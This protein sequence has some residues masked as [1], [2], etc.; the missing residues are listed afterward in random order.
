[1]ST[2]L[3]NY[4]KAVQSGWCIVSS[5]SVFSALIDAVLFELTHEEKYNNASNERQ[6]EWRSEVASLAIAYVKETG[7]F[8][9]AFGIIAMEAHSKN[10][11]SYNGQF[12]TPENV[13]MFSGKAAFTDLSYSRVGVNRFDVLEPTCGTGAMVFGLLKSVEQMSPGQLA[14]INVVT[15]ELS[16]DYA[17]AFYAN[18]LLSE[19]CH[20]SSGV[21]FTILRG[22]TLEK[23]LNVMARINCSTEDHQI[24][25]PDKIDI[26]ML[27]FDLIIGNPPFGKININDDANW[28]R[29]SHKKPELDSKQFTPSVSLKKSV[30]GE[31]IFIDLATSLLK[32]DGV[33]AFVV[34][35]G[36]L[37]NSKSRNFRKYLL[38]HHAV[39]CVVSFPNTLFVNTGTTVKTSLLMIK[40][41]S[42]CEADVFM[43]VVD[44]VGWDSRD[45]PAKDEIPMVEREL[46]SF[47]LHVRVGEGANVSP[48]SHGAVVSPLT[49][50]PGP[51]NADDVEVDSA[52]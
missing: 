31:E 13:S 26:R 40:N 37:S 36:I 4:K 39:R 42:A 38:N 7:N 6:Q 20:G 19:F 16:Y 24:P 34:P 29:T 30:N 9:D 43:A 45:R 1:M 21:N 33:M 51:Q 23:D 32:K 27:R 12:F 49:N 3:L 17:R 8:T 14:N 11:R 50:Q 10:G 35:D 47:L 41:S 15:C 28:L 18:V 52:A 48:I 2:A 44:S 25:V 46:Y 5:G 22:N